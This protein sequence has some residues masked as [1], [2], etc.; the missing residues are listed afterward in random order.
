VKSQIMGDQIRVSGKS[1]D[2]LQKVIQTLKAADLP[3]ELQF[4]NYR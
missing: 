1:R 3:I 2:D 4:V